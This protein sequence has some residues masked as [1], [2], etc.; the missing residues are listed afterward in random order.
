M[1]DKCS[2]YRVYLIPG[3][4]VAFPL[5]FLLIRGVIRTDTQGEDLT[6][7]SVQ[8]VSE[9]GKEGADQSISPVRKGTV[10]DLSRL[11]SGEPSGVVRVPA[12]EGRGQSP[13]SE[14]VQK[15]LKDIKPPPSPLQLDLRIAGAILVDGEGSY[16]IIMDETTGKQGTYR[17]GESIKGA[18]VLKIYKESIALE[19]DG[20]TQVLR[21]TRDRSIEEAPSEMGTG[22]R[23]P[24]I[25]VS[26]D[27]SSFE[28]VISET[29][30]VPDESIQVKEL[31]PFE[32]VTNSAGPVDVE[33]FYEELPEFTPTPP[34]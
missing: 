13:N 14:E 26:K 32:P 2:H 34:N 20:G 31:P 29:G 19:K 23:P 15:G 21:V 22:V 8:E 27:I 4:L 16:A 6:P 12:I 9:M 18:T 33:G 17:L 11:E 28:P 24:S 5:A 30:P 7:L 1:R 10:P 25:G 3:L